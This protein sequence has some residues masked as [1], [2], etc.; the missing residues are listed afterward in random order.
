M[1]QS[2]F[3]NG[4][5]GNAEWPMWSEAASLRHGQ[6][7]ACR[8]VRCSS[9]DALYLR[10]ERVSYNA[11]P[12][13]PAAVTHK[14]TP[15]ELRIRLMGATSHTAVG[16]S[17][18]RLC[19]ARSSPTPGHAPALGPTPDPIV[20][21]TPKRTFRLAVPPTLSRAA[22]V[23]CS[24][25]LFVRCTNPFVTPHCSGG[26]TPSIPSPVRCTPAGFGVP[27]QC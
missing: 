5:L 14:N 16:Q 3:E 18:T 2:A 23:A 19:A 20:H 15:F 1:A 21:C 17:S 25:A 13:A 24:S 8:S 27:A 26:Y 6:R 9:V 22:C 4:S 11:Q 7:E 12:E 10:A